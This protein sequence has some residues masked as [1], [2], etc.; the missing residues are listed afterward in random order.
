MA[1]KGKIGAEIEIRSPASKFFN[2]YVTQIHELQNISD[3]VH[4]T[5]LHQ[6][7]WHGVGSHSV[8]H[9]TLTIESTGGKAVSIKEHFEGIDHAN[10]TLLF[11]FFDGATSEKYKNKLK[12]KLKVVD[13]SQ[14][15]ALVKWS[16]R[17]EKLHE[18]M[19]PPQD[20]MDFFTKLT[21][22]VDAHL[23]KA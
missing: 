13:K 16:F 23:L 22:D 20:Y 9:W 1:L 7:D 11:N 2:V 21:E 6:G 18:A 19:P 10:K 12:G 14:G 3:G 4:Q 17:Y 15:G 5:K 8:K